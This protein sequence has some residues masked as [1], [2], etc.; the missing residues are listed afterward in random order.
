M[1]APGEPDV[2][3]G[4]V[5]RELLGRWP[6]TRLDVA[7]DVTS[8]LDNRGGLAARAAPATGDHLLATGSVVTVADARCALTTEPDPRPGDPPEPRS[9]D[10]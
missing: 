1:I 4:Q 6:E 3:A 10:S 2:L 8:G 5:G 9:T 7:A